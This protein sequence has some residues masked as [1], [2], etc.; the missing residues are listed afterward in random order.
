MITLQVKYKKLKNKKHIIQVNDR[1]G[2]CLYN[3][4]LFIRKRIL[5]DGLGRL[6]EDN[7]KQHYQESPLIAVDPNAPSFSKWVLSELGQCLFY[8]SVGILGLAWFIG[9]GVALPFYPVMLW[10]S[11]Q[12]QWIKIAGTVG[13][14][15][16]YWFPCLYWC[17]R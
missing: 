6:L 10:F 9:V 1:A 16:L 11:S 17:Y 15:V 7:F 12:P 5:E 4:E 2:R 14:V 13:G 3:N 8:L